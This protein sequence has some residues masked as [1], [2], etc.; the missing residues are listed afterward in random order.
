MC[1]AQQTQ[2]KELFIY[3]PH[4]GRFTNRYSRGRAKEG[5]IAGAETGHGYRRIIIDYVKHYEHHLAWLYMYGTYP[6]EVDHKNG[7]RD[8]NR[9]ANLRLC[10][11]T[12]NCFNSL[13]PT[14]E[15]GLK[16]AYLDKRNLQW[17]SKI[18]LGGQQ[19]FLG[20]F[21]TALEA[22]NAYMAAVDL[23]HGEFA[24]HHRKQPLLR[25]I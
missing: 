5:E 9:I 24:L 16:G 7:I 2:L 21:S 1:E 15:S 4:T 17:Y 18:Q 12:E 10:N 13:R 8:D 22:H 6:Y 3:N 14:G 20:N 25:R 11:R 19:K 23:H